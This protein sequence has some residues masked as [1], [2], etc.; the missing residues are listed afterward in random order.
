MIGEKGN[1]GSLPSRQIG[2]PTKG[3]RAAPLYDPDKAKQLLIELQQIVH[4]RTI[5]API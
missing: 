2:G 1:A 3:A 5:Y 4:E